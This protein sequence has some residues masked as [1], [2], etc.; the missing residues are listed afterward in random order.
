MGSENSE[1]LNSECLYSER[2]NFERLNSERLNFE[3]LNFERLNYEHLNSVDFAEFVG[4]GQPGFVSCDYFV[5][6]GDFG[7]SE[8]PNLSYFVDFVDF[9]DSIGFSAKSDYFVRFALFEAFHSAPMDSE[10]ADS[11]AHQHS[12]C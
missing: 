7:C 6:F 5:G 10:P 11:S 12:D 1:H 9:V 8:S 2:L 4:S 3:R